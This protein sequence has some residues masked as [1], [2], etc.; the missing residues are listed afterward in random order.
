MNA[1]G[2][3]SNQITLTDAA[4][5]RAKALIDKSEKPILGLRVGVTTMG[6]NGH[7]YLVEYA[8]QKK[9]LEESFSE[10]EAEE[11]DED[12]CDESED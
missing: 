6:C 9:P 8:E 5:E 7:S 10:D 12:D 4:I 3:K 11:M 1:T 2:P